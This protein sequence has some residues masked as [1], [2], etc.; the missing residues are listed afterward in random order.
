Q[1]VLQLLATLGR[2]GQLS[3]D[4]R[5]RHG[6]GVSIRI[7]ACLQ[8]GVLRRGGPVARVHPQKSTGTSAGVSSASVSSGCVPMPSF[9]LILA[10]ISS[11][12]SGLSLMNVRAFSLP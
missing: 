1:R 7:R 4:D 5:T 11:P 2:A 8:V 9:S 6:I 3:E 12:S 10:S